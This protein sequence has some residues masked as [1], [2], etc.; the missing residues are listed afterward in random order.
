MIL[1]ALFFIGCSLKNLQNFFM[2]CLIQYISYLVS[3]VLN[4]I[5]NIDKTG[6]ICSLT[7]VMN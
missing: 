4:D 1:A 2:Q 5:V 7:F 6:G 3:M